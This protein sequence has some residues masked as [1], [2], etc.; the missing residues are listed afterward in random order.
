MID[1]QTISL[2]SSDG[3]TFDTF[4][5]T[6]ASPRGSV[7]VLQE[8]FGVNAHIQSI[9]HRIA[10]LGVTA[11]AP[12]LFDRKEKAVSLP[13]DQTGVA[14][15]KTLISCIP[16]D[17]A[18]VD[19]AAAV[20]HASASGP[21]AVLGFC[22]GGSLAWLA[23][24]HLPVAGAIAYYGGQIGGLLDKTPAKPVMTHFGAADASIPMEVPETLYRNFGTVINHVYPAGHG[25]NCEARP[26]FD[27]E[28]ANLAWAR[29]AG[30]LKALM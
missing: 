20:E 25:F 9:A 21:V 23:A 7:I 15:G 19:V 29:T 22:W 4:T 17:T 10:E 24:H 6:P 11:I 26:S 27:L 1:T 8:I 13:Y 2:R 28:C 16:L 12:A 30:F 3:H 5:A 14:K 18:M